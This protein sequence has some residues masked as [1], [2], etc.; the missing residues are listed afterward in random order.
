MHRHGLGKNSCFLG[1]ISTLF[2]SF[3]V[4][5]KTANR[6]RAF[7]EILPDPFLRVSLGLSSGNYVLWDE[8][9]HRTL[10]G[11]RAL[12]RFVTCADRY[13]TGEVAIQIT[14][15]AGHTEL[16]KWQTP[17]RKKWGVNS[18]VVIIEVMVNHGE[19]AEKDCPSFMPALLEAP[20]NC[21]DTHRMGQAMSALARQKH[22]SFWGE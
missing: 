14:G 5:S 7:L 11:P 10:A 9:L 20:T 15:V 2:H 3:V 17:G 16:N 6:S 19:I 4:A 1:R 8:L 22:H 18:S 12:Q 21:W 13:N